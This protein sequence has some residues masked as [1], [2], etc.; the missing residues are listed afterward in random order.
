MP[1]KMLVFHVHVI[2]LLHN[3][4]PRPG[5]VVKRMMCRQAE[6]NSHHSG[7][8]PFMELRGT[9][10]VDLDLGL[11]AESSMSNSQSVAFSCL[12]SY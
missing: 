6:M 11:D 3:S 5:R 7:V 2:E 1:V 10:A 9:V 4:K 8:V 12:A